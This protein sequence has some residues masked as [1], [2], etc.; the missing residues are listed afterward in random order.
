MLRAS[1]PPGGAFAPRARSASS[2][3]RTDAAAD[4]VPEDAGDAEEAEADLRG[5]LQA[6]LSALVA[7]SSETFRRRKGTKSGTG[8]PERM[9][10]PG[11]GPPATRRPCRFPM[12]DSAPAERTLCRGRGGPSQNRRGLL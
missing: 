1:S 2:A 9:R 8:S 10:K 7:D 5:T 11:G 4:R 12:G 6:R 3:A